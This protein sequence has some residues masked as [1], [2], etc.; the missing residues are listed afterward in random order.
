M[1]H[2]RV[3]RVGL[4]SLAS[5]GSVLG[6]LVALPPALVLAALCRPLVAGG[7]GLLEGWQHVSLGLLSID[8]VQ[9]LHLDSLLVTVQALDEVGWWLSLALAGLLCASA[10]VAAGLAALSTGLGYNL[11]ARL[12]GG[13]EVELEPVL[14]EV[15]DARSR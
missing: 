11:L 13:V 14:H 3:R 15:G 12:S 6:A 9:A 4:F 10:G 7:R 1:K 5:L 8:A 2:Y